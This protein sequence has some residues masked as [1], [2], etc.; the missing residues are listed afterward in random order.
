MT[1]AEILAKAKEAGRRQAQAVIASRNEVLKNR[2]QSIEETTKAQRR[3]KQ[4]LISEENF[5]KLGPQSPNVLIA[6][7]DSWF[8]YFHHDILRILEN[9][10][11]YDVESVAHRGDKVENMA[12]GEGQLENF[13]R[14]VEK[15]L[16][17]NVIPKAILL[18]GG[19]ND[20]AGAEFGMLLN[21]AFSNIAGLNDSIIRGVVDERAKLAYVTIIS[22]ITEV[23]K[24]Y[25]PKWTVPILVHG[26]DY[27]VPDGRGVEFLGLHLSGPWLE[28]GFREKGFF[29]LS[30]RITIVR[31]LMERFN[32]MLNDLVS[33]PQFS[34]VHYVDL[35][36]TLSTA[37]DNY[38]DYWANEF[39]PTRKGFEKVTQRF[40]DVLKTLDTP[41]MITEPRRS[42]R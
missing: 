29:E 18:S 39:H 32:K 31:T 1:T 24:H 6:E 17:R 42:R 40:V 37:L 36:N 14:L 15:T 41:I 11:G 3:V 8:D 22:K 20:I 30:N 21:H 26:Y 34:H 33:D 2:K 23:C 16:R 35:R 13:S 38:T 19:G 4:V 10:H 27:P 9:D 28:P 7:G 12:Y 25:T 5:N